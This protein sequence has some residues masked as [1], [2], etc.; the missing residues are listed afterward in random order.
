MKI[1]F[2][3]YIKPTGIELWNRLKLNFS[4]LNEHTFYH[5]FWD[6]VNPLC[7]CNVETKTTR[8]YHLCYSLFS[9]QSTNLLESICNLDNTL[10]NYCDDNHVDI[11]FYGS[12]KYS[13]STNNK[14][15][16]VLTNHSWITDNFYGRMTSFQRRQELSFLLETS[17]GRH[18]NV[19]TT[20]CAQ[21]ATVHR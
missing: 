9:E 21:L 14:L 5:N 20:S 13:F 17:S 19:R 10:L 8:H 2:L 18:N 4:H 12:S 16:N 7:L 6:A 3:M 15:Q 1:Q 11:L